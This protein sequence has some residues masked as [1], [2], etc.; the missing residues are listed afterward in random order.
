MVLDSAFAG[1]QHFVANG[2]TFNNI[3]GNYVVM[4]EASDDHA[5]RRRRRTFLGLCELN[6]EDVSL[7]RQIYKGRGYRLYSALNKKSGEIVAVKA[8][9][10][11]RANER[12]RDYARFMIEHKVMHSNIP[13]MIALSS[14]SSKM[15]FLI[16]DGEYDGTVDHM[17]G[18]VLMRGQQ[19]SLISGL[20][21]VT[22]LSSGLDYLQDLNYPF[23]SVGL[24]HFSLLSRKG[25]V[26][27]NFDPDRLG[28]MTEPSGQSSSAY[29]GLQVFHGL[30]QKTF[31][32]ASK[33]HYK[34]KPFFNVIANVTKFAQIM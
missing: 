4:A 29:T 32:G 19:Q 3:L 25:K 5:S 31:E 2:A 9:E 33:I 6:N 10:G 7:E 21:T 18:V 23:E 13:H 17:L 28:Q 15:P 34:S 1:A 8:Y 24:D 30:I 11:S 14:R 26:I 20:Q 16:Y 22:D 27:I 12:C